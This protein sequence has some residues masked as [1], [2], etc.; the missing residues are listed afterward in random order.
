MFNPGTV[1]CLKRSEGT[2]KLWITST[3]RKLT[4]T[5]RSTGKYIVPVTTSSFAAGSDVFN[6]TAASPPADGS[7]SFGLVAPYFPSGPGYRKYQAN[8]IPV[9]S[10]CTAPGPAWSKRWLAHTRLP[11][12]F[13]PTKST[14]VS[15]VQT[16]SRLVLPCEY[17]TGGEEGCSRYFQTRYPKESC[18]ARKTIPINTKVRASCPSMNFAASAAP[19]GSHQVLATKK[20]VL[21]REISQITASNRRP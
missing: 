12:R 9:T 17:C 21:I 20:Y 19:T 16:I 3:A 8:C 13:N 11:I 18:A 7:I 6:P 4:S 2:K 1:S 14:V 10:T 5:S 15:T